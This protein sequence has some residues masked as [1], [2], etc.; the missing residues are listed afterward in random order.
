[1]ARP[2]RR[3]DE[4]VSTLASFIGVIILVVAILGVYY[5]YVVPKFGAPPLRAQSGDQVQV[6][7]IGTFSD[8]GLVFDTSLQFVATD[9]ATYAKAFM[10][11]WHAWQPLPLTIGSRGVVKRFDLGIQ[12]LVVGASI[13]LLVP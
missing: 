6:N 3:D 10:F 12:A 2:L 7:Y 8:T 1:M 4:G 9:N 5:G 13:A 11:S